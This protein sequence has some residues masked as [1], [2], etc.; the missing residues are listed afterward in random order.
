MQSPKVRVLLVEDDNVD[1]MAFVRLLRS[2]NLAHDHVRAS[3]VAEGRKAFQNHTFDLVLFSWKNNL[4]S[5]SSL[6]VN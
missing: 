4:C 5:G 2:K 6:R 1:D 3:S